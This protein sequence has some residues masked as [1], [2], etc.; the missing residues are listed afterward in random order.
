M[1][2][3]SPRPDSK[4]KTPLPP[5]APNPAAGPVII[6]ACVDEALARIM[7]RR[8]GPP[9]TPRPPRIEAAA[10]ARR[11]TRGAAAIGGRF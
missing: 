9:P 8:P 3:I 7:A 1:N 2:T 5:P 4:S 11:T 6:G 10:G